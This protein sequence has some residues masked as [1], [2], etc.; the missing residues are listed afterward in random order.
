[1]LSRL[2]PENIARLSSR[3]PKTVVAAWVLALV[4]G[5]MAAAT[6]LSGA[7][8]ND[9]N[10]TNQPESVRARELIEQRLG[11][12]DETSEIVVFQSDSLTVDDPAY[13]T[14]VVVR[15]RRI[16]GAGPGR[17]FGNRPLLRRPRR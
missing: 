17:G 8:T 11:E 16:G 6:L 3:R 14:V 7:L 9:V 15:D 5:L 4:L 12:Q 13:Q 1:M 10:L 2:F